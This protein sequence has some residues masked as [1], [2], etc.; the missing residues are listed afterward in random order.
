MTAYMR[1]RVSSCVTLTKDSIY[2]DRAADQQSTRTVI[3]H[4]AC[5]CVS[6]LYECHSSYLCFDAVAHRHYVL[7]VQRCLDSW[8][9]RNV[10][11]K[12]LRQRILVV[13][14]LIKVFKE[15]SQVR[16]LVVL[17]E[18]GSTCLNVLGQRS[19]RVVRRLECV[20]LHINRL[21]LRTQS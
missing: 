16:R 19:R 7:D 2:G 15:R 18:E 14:L 17:A 11:A 21:D 5:E 12:H 8:L 13:L 10:R 6:C 9:R 3:V 4:V 20:K 1:V